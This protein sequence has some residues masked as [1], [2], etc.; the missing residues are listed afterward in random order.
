MND[1][2]VLSSMLAL[3]AIGAAS[4]AV[5]MGILRDDDDDEWEQLTLAID[6]ARADW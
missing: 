5:C 1:M 6:A 3:V 2:T 4:I